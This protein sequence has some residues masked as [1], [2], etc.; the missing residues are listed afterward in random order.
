MENVITT[1]YDYSKEKRGVF[2]LIDSKSFYASVEN[3]ERGFNPLKGDL[4]VMSEQANTNVGLVLAASPTAKKDLGISNVMRQRDLPDIHGL[5]IAN[6]R[7]NN[8][9]AENLKINNI[10]RQYTDDI[11]LLPYSID[12]SI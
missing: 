3:V 4:V 7:M 2:F 5:F 12:E 1:E 11:N 9:I 10:Y 8:Y 6:P